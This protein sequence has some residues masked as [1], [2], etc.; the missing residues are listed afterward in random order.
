MPYAQAERA[1]FEYDRRGRIGW[2][3]DDA[4]Q[5]RARRVCSRGST[6]LATRGCC[7]SSL[8]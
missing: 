6:R 5:T 3:G 4:I 2:H 1:A 7:P 8:M